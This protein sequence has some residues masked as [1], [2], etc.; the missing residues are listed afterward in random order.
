VPFDLAMLATF[1]G[2]TSLS[3]TNYRLLVEER[4][5]EKY[6]KLT[7]LHLINNTMHANFLP[8]D[9]L[10]Q[11]NHLTFQ[12]NVIHRTTASLQYHNFK[13]RQRKN[14]YSSLIA[15]GSPSKEQT[16]ELHLMLPNVSVLAH[17][18]FLDLQNNSLNETRSSSLFDTLPNL[19][20]LQTLILSNND[21]GEMPA[22]LFLLSSL[23]RLELA[24]NLVIRIPVEV[25]LLKDL[26]VSGKHYLGMM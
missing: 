19:S 6:A 22:S 10:I 7:Q 25:G 17:L 11:L 15:S 9:H 3:I 24:K 23:R 21:L 2:P 4:T 16:N 8:T 5:F 20:N 26:E 1:G 18:V 13:L 14:T 12:N